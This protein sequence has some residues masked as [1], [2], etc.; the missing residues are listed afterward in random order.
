M[1][2]IKWCSNTYTT[3]TSCYHCCYIIRC[4][5]N[6][7]CLLCTCT[8]NEKALASVTTAADA[9]FTPQEELSML[10][11]SY[12]DSI[13]MLTLTCNKAR[14]FDIAYCSYYAIQFAMHCVNVIILVL[15]LK[16][17]SHKLST[18]HNWE[19]IWLWWTY[20]IHGVNTYIC[21]I[22][23]RNKSATLSSHCKTP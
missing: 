9:S 11:V 7:Y 19:W 16:W 21:I 12:Y 5:P 10:T 17:Y 22:S 15:Y 8:I 14:Q 20:N 6:Q 3:A 18:P 4:I 1:C 13:A 2:L 23:D